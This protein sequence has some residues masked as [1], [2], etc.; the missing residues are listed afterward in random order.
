MIHIDRIEDGVATLVFGGVY[1]IN[2]PAKY[3]PKGCKGGD[4][5]KLVKDENV[6]RKLKRKAERL[7][8]EL[9]G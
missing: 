1:N 4:V 3:L 5:F 2:V 8:G 9:K 7:L 6:T